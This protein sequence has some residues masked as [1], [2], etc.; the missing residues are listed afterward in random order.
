M[1]KAEVL[2]TIKECREKGK[3]RNFKQ[4]FDFILNL[5]GIDIK[6]PENQKEIFI[7]LPHMP[8]K[9]KVCALVGGELKA[10]ADKICDKAILFD[11]FAQYSKDK[12]AVKKLSNDYDYFIAQADVMAQVATHF[13]KVFGPRGKMPNPKAGCLVP[14]KAPIK[15]IYDRLQNMA[16]AAWKKSLVLQAY[17]GTEDMKDDLIADNVM[18]YYTTVLH[19]L[20]N[21]MHNIKST[22]LKLTMGAPIR[23][24]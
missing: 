2:K 17:V 13:G 16:K 18:A 12:K 21:E 1:D 5:K 8:K 19:S 10:E 9:R 3:K 24:R 14:K 11:E 22:Y 23:I 4:G 20:P 7:P 6:K 15:P